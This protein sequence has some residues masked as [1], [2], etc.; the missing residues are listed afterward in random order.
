MGAV[1][2]IFKRN[3]VHIEDVI[4]NPAKV[5]DPLLKTLDNFALVS[6]M[7]GVLFSLTIGVA[8][9][10]NSYE[11]R[12]LKMADE[13]SK[14]TESH[15]L[16]KFSVDGISKLKPPEQKPTTPQTSELPPKQK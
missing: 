8:T 6:F 14:S 7:L 1:L 4:E 13:K 11:E 15:K 5:K 12:V 2:W 10:Y 9:A 16:E 3:A